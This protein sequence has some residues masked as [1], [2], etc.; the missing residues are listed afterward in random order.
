MIVI[1]AAW[2]VYKTFPRSIDATLTG[3]KYQLSA[4]GAKASTEPVTVVIQGKLYTSLKGEHTF[5]G[6][7]TIVGEQIP[8]PLDQRKLE[9]HFARE[10]WGVMAYPYFHYYQRG[11][12]EGVDIY[13]S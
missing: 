10:G 3:I 7:V 1:C 8:V 12:V 13:S 5:K 11:A 9:I 6:E 4:K 2:I